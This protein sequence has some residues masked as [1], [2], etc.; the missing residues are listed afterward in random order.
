MNI[1]FLFF[2]RHRFIDV[3]NIATIGCSNLSETNDRSNSQLKLRI[4]ESV[5]SVKKKNQ[6]DL[7]MVYEN[8][9]VKLLNNKSLQNTD[10]ISMEIKN[11]QDVDQEEN[12]FGDNK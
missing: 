6:I 5:L 4:R 11:G 7:K 8:S 1:N 2:F 9:E 10:F 3:W 12:L